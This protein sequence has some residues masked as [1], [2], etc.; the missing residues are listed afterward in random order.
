[1]VNKDKTLM[2]TVILKNLK[3]RINLRIV[4]DDRNSAGIII[5]IKNKIQLG[6]L[7][8]EIERTYNIEIPYIKDYVNY[9]DDRKYRY[10]IINSN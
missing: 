1:M 3:N 2:Q 9:F 6:G 4:N 5:P 8:F 10:L 7:L